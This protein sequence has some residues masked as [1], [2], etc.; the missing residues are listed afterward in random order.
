MR[1]YVSLWLE[2]AHNPSLSSS[3]IEGASGYGSVWLRQHG[4]GRNVQKG[5]NA[6][7]T[8]YLR[9]GHTLRSTAPCAEMFCICY[10]KRR[11][12]YVTFIKHL[13][14]FDSKILTSMIPMRKCKYTLNTIYIPSI[15]HIRHWQH[16]LGYYIY[17]Y[18]YACVCVCCIYMYIYVTF[19]YFAHQTSDTISLI[20]WYTRAWGKTNEYMN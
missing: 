1:S 12:T 7:V 5:I 4:A 19:H 10:G 3:D 14:V 8:Q 18:M 16:V 15:F 17:I 9:L 13:D 20:T 11:I 2:V 6:L